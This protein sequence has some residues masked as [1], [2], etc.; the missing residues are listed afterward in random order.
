MTL[1]PTPNRRTSIGEA[2]ANTLAGFLF[3]LVGLCG[4]G[5]VGCGGVYRCVAEPTSCL[6][7][8]PNRL[9]ASIVMGVVACVGLSMVAQGVRRR[10]GIE[11]FFYVKARRFAKRFSP[12]QVWLA[13]FGLSFVAEALAYVLAA[14]TPSFH[15]KVSCVLTLA[16]LHIVLHELGHFVAAR[17]AGFEPHQIIA[18]PVAVAVSQGSTIVS[19]NKDWR[20]VIGGVVLWSTWGPTLPKHQFLIA[21]AGPAATAGLLLLGLVVGLA[22]PSS[23]A[24]TSVLDANLNI[25]VGTLAIN[26]LPIQISRMGVASDGY[27]MLEASRQMRH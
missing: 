16:L 8:L 17:A 11:G 13:V 19:A 2:V 5:V 27:L 14:S 15:F 23:A 21:A 4:A 20:F 9:F 10:R 26:L 1:S 24:L 3:A 6:Q 25:G 12:N 22:A 18:G 7:D